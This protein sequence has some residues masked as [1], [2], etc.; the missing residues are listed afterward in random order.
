[1]SVCVLFQFMC[2]YVCMIACVWTK[3]VWTSVL[4]HLMCVRSCVCVCVYDCTC[5]DKR[6]MSSHVCALMCVNVCVYVCMRLYA[7]YS[8]SCVCMCV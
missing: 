8:I 5:V 7:S 1:M 6:V 3:R 2:V 4:C